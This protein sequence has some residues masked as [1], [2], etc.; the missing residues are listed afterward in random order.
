VDVDYLI[1][2]RLDEIAIEYPHEP[3]KANEADAVPAQQNIGCGGKRGAVMRDHDF[4][5]DA[6]FR[7]PFET[8][9]FGPVADDKPDF[10]RV[11]RIGACLDQRL[12]VRSPAGN[13]HRDPQRLPRGRGSTKVG[14][15]GSA[16]DGILAKTAL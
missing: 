14:T 9:R 5:R 15:G 16:V 3:G 1:A 11:S 4:S 2:P 10:C 12:Q 7:R 13:Q 6:G 8:L